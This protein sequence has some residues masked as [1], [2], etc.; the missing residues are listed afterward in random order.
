MTLLSARLEYNARVFLFRNSS[1]SLLRIFVIL[2]EIGMFLT[3]MVTS[4]HN[5]NNN[6]NNNNNDNNNNNNLEL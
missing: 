1:Q 2:H 3:S 6:N 5:N 4:L